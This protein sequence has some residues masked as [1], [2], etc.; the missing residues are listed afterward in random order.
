LAEG[1]EFTQAQCVKQAAACTLL[2]GGDWQ[3]PSI[4]QMRTIEDLGT[5]SPALKAPFNRFFP[6]HGWAWTRSD[7]AAPDYADCAWG[8]LLH[9]GLSSIS[10]R[11]GRGVALA[12]RPVPGASPRQ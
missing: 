1:K 2:D 8:V 6:R 11:Y 3:L 12:C 4:Q 10:L 7:A 5:H 9:R